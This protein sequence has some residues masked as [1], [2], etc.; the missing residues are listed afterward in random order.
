MSQELSKP[1]RIE[2]ILRQIDALPTL[3]A[4]ATRLLQLTAREDSHAREVVEL[5]SADPPLTAKVLSLC[6]TADRGIH[7]DTLTVDRA[8]ILLGFNAIRNAVLSIKVV[9]L[10]ERAEDEGNET[11]SL[12][13]PAL[14]MHSLAVAVIAESL[15][16]R[17]PHLKVKP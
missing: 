15:A 7:R 3:P 4:I 9:E 13:R 11:K 17:H 1:K 10:F 6:R 14:W 8:V 16:Q 2:L 12:D 5:V